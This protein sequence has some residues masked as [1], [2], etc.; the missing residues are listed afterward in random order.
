MRTSGAVKTEHFFDGVFAAKPLLDIP[1]NG[2]H[3]ERLGCL[4]SGCGVCVCTTTDWL[5]SNELLQT[6]IV[7]L[8]NGPPT[9]T[10]VIAR[11]GFTRC[12]LRL[13]SVL[14]KTAVEIIHGTCTG[15]VKG[16]A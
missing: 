3:L 5:W 11:R 14:L 15:P 9:L 12:L 4:I 10:F 16:A 2:L 7:A 1:V 6:P 13:A 8:P